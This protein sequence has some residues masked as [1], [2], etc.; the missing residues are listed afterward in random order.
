MDPYSQ[1]AEERLSP[2]LGTD[3]QSK[4][5][6]SCCFN[7]VGEFGEGSSVPGK[8]YSGGIVFFF[9]TL[10]TRPL[11]SK[12]LQCLQRFLSRPRIAFSTTRNELRGLWEWRCAAS[13]FWDYTLETTYVSGAGGYSCQEW[14][15]I[16]NVPGICVSYRGKYTPWEYPAVYIL[17]AIHEVSLALG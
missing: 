8:L 9:G 11:L 1:G 17:Y 4:H 13:W 6:K 16:W 5:L 14:K 2:E 12:W 10:N 3:V 7:S 15:N